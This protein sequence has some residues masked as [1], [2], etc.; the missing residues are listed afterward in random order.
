MTGVSSLGWLW[1]PFLLKATVIVGSGGLIFGY[2]IGVISGTLSTL[3]S[4]FDLT[5]YEEGLVV[6]ILYAGSIVG[7]IFGGPLCDFIG[8]WK[9]IQVQ[10]A[11][12]VLGAII[13]GL[14]INKSWLYLGRFLVGVASSISGLADVPYLTEIAPPEYRGILSGQYEILV[15]FGILLSFSLDVAF[16]GA[17][18]GWRIAFIIPGALALSQSVAMLWLPESPKWLLSK[19]KFID[20]RAAL[21]CVYGETDLLLWKQAYITDRSSSSMDKAGQAHDI[22]CDV[23]ELFR[24]EDQSGHSPL[25]HGTEPLLS[26][27]STAVLHQLWGSPE[28]R[29]VVREYSYPIS[30]VIAFQILSQVTG[31]NVVRNYAAV[32]FESNGASKRLSL[33]LNVVLGVVKW[34]STVL[35]VFYVEDHG[36]RLLFLWGSAFVT[37]GMLVLTVASLASP[38][39]TLHSVAVFIVGCVM[40]YAGFGIGYGPIPWIL[41]SEMIP[42]Q[43]RGRVMSWT[44]IASNL[45][46]LVTNFAFLPMTHAWTTSGS[47]G[48]FTVLNVATWWVVYVCLCETK[49]ILPADIKRLLHDRYE[50]FLWRL[51]RP[52]KCCP[53]GHERVNMTDD[54]QGSSEVYGS[55]DEG[56]RKTTRTSGQGTMLDVSVSAASSEWSTS[57]GQ[58]VV[59]PLMDGQ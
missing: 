47:F 8:R 55:V 40:I 5:S 56:T 25:L 31:S 36:R 58:P 20:A 23:V 32:I 18:N 53:R 57:A 22:P 37:V 27:W 7:C 49:D 26:S 35:A 13:T 52:L 19:R 59:N 45:A 51:R 50:D 2:D 4:T 9:T 17:A 11:I 41:S 48:M 10:N 28:E 43:I 1:D 38:Q 21:K 6:S 24:G 33:V 30:L 44:L 14:A 42:T 12:F 29:S 15:A 34:L 54:E 16:A 46:Q 39:F 3:Q